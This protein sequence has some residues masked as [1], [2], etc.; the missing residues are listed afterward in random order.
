MDPKKYTK[1]MLEQTYALVLCHGSQFLRCESGAWGIP[2]RF[3]LKEARDGLPLPNN[4]KHWNSGI[5]LS[6]TNCEKLR[7]LK[8]GKKVQMS[9]DKHAHN[10]WW[11]LR[12]DLDNENSLEKQI[13][14]KDE[15]LQNIQVMIKKLVGSLQKKER[16]LRKELEL[17]QQKQMKIS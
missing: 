17:L 6:K 10:N 5:Q 8:P 14:E 13:M 1:E 15:E 9:F 2:P 3:T 16:K 12:L 4:C 11:A 7:R